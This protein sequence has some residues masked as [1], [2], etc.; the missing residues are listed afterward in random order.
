MTLDDWGVRT[1]LDIDATMFWKLPKSSRRGTATGRVIS[2]L[3]CIASAPR[4]HATR[5]R[6][7]API[8]AGGKRAGLATSDI[9]NHLRDQG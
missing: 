2:E 8:L 3:A 1:T 9:V 7:G 6:N 5:K 4:N